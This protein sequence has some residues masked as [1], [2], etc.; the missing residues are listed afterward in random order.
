MSQRARAFGWGPLSLAGLALGAALAV[1]PRPELLARMPKVYAPTVTGKPAK[2]HATYYQVFT[3]P[4]TP[5]NP[6]AARGAPIT[7]GARIPASIP[8][9]TSNTV[10]VVEAG[11]P[12]PWTKPQD[13]PYD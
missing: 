11:E 8:D 7:L 4:D 12:V 6:K 10:L 13:L 5:F 3:G 9:G 1:L 2:P